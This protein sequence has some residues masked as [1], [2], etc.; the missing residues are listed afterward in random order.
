MLVRSFRKIIK[1]KGSCQ[2]IARPKAT[3]KNAFKFDT[4][5][6][7]THT[8]ARTWRKKIN[9]FCATKLPLRHRFAT[10][11]EPTSPR[12]SLR[13]QF[14]CSVFI[15]FCVLCLFWWPKTRCGNICLKFILHMF[16]FVYA[17][18]FP[19]VLCPFFLFAAVSIVALACETFFRW[20]I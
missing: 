8:Q 15:L 10:D 17:M 13:F 7:H 12:C 6:A 9:K 3:G 1:Q 11:H 16:I 2:D 5:T 18:L 19:F 4:H 20:V 14:F